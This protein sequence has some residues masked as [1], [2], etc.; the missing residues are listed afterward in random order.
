MLWLLLLMELPRGGLLR[1]ELVQLLL[2]VESHV[3]CHNL[4]VLAALLRRLLLLLGLVLL[5]V[6]H[7]V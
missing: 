7:L 5:G 6:R 2:L 1:V 3:T 4:L